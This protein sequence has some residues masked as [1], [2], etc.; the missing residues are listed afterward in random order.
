M[1]IPNNPEEIKSAVASGKVVVVKFSASWCGPCRALAPH[2][3]AMAQEFEPLG[4]IFYEIDVKGD[5]TE[6]A[7]ENNAR[8]VP[9]V[10]I[11]VKG[12]LLGFVRGNN[13]DGVRNGIMSALSMLS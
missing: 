5:W 6:Y 7:L 1:R 9:Y 13:P 8:T 3:H 11:F 12:N 4:A 2:V 10:Q